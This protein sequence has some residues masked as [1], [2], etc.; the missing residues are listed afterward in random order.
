MSRLSKICLASLR[1]NWIY[2]L[3]VVVTYGFG[4]VLGVLALDYLKADQAGE[5]NEYLN[6]FIEQAGGLSIDAQQAVKSSTINNLSV[7]VVIY[8]LG[9]TVIGIPMILLLLFVRGF[10]IGFA[11]GFLTKQKAWQGVILALVSI[12]PHNFFYVPALLIATVASLSFSVLLVKRF[13][14]SKLAI[15]PSFIGY[16][17][18]LLAVCAVA[19]GA[20]FVETYLTPYLIK[21]TAA[22]FG[23]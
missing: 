5:L 20:S 15:W 23:G 8:L 22:M 19:V 14:N 18:I 9:L 7:I 13:F 1:A 17:L 4:C 12:L 2:L 3:I 21:S 10:A 11:I 6:M 16:N